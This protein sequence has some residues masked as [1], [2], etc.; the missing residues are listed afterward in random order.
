MVWNILLYH[1]DQGITNWEVGMSLDHHFLCFPQGWTEKL[2][3]FQRAYMSDGEFIRYRAFSDVPR[4]IDPDADDFAGKYLMDYYM[5]N[6]KNAISVHDRIILK[7]LRRF[8]SVDTFFIGFIPCVGLNYYG[9][10]LIPWESLPEFVD[11]IKKIPKN[12]EANKLRALG[13]EA[14]IN[15]EDILHCGI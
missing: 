4:P 12:S 9:L 15:H 11:V 8:A 6:K 14:Y 2:V 1:L 10:T 7:N 13:Q 5:A 3:R